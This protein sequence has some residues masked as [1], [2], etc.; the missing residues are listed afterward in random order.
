MSTKEASMRASVILPLALA[1]AVVATPPGASAQTFD[2]GSTGADG[3]LAPVSGTVTLTLP[4]SGVFNFTTIN[5]PAAV[6]LKFTRNA[7]NTPVTLLASGAVTIAGTIDIRGGNASNGGGGTPLASN[8]GL[9]GPGGFDGGS[10]ANGVAATLGGSGLGPGG[11][12]GVSGSGGGGSFGT[13]GTNSSNGGLGGPTYGTEALLPII[14]GSGGAGGGSGLGSFSGGGGGGGGAILIAS[15]STITFT[16]SITAAGGAGG[17]GI[18]SPQA[19]GGGAGGAVRLVATTVTGNNG[20]IDVRGGNLSSVI[21]ALY[22]TGGNGRLRVEAFTRT[23][24]LNVNGVAPSLAQPTVVALSNGPLLTITSVAG[25]AAP[26]AP[27]GSFSFPDITLP[28]TTAN[29]VSVVLS[30]V[31]IPSGTTVTLSASG[32]TGGSASTTATLTGSLAATSASASLTIPTN[33]PSLL[34]ATVT[35]TL[36]AAGGG[37]PLFV[38]GEPVDTVRVTAAWGGDSQVTYITRSGREIVMAGAR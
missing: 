31:N 4:P 13:A 21:G 19:G 37:G 11:S 34:L 36:T 2:S 38:E 16:G 33:R 23:A 27:A 29:P 15:S 8:G 5:I 6:T 9:G 22:G 30:G 1:V 14:G 7:A 32:Q 17:G 26:A 12:V 20:N 25:V 10:G 3:A 24:V 35:F 18:G 28:A